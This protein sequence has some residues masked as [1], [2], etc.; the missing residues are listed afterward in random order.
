MKRT[1]P[2]FAVVLGVFGAMLTGI[3]PASA[4]PSGVDCSAGGYTRAYAG[5]IYSNYRRV[6]VDGRQYGLGNPEPVTYEI[7][8]D[9][10]DDST[11]TIEVRSW[12]NQVETVFVDDR[13]GDKIFRYTLDTPMSF[14]QIYGTMTG[15]DNTVLNYTWHEKQIPA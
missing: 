8:L 7:C 4:A 15:P 3:G 10:P 14:W 1:T 12:A 5:W 9:I 11:F 2:V 6:A 13:P